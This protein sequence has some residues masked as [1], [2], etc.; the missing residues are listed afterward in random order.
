MVPHLHQRHV[1][2]SHSSSQA[3]IKSQIIVESLVT[4]LKL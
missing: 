2:S 4:K 3:Q 1:D